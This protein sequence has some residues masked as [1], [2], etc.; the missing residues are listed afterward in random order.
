[1]PLPAVITKQLQS[2]TPHLNVQKYTLSKSAVKSLS[3][4][5]NAHPSLTVL[6]L[7]H[8]GLTSD[9]IESLCR[10]IETHPNLKFLD[11]SGNPGMG[12]QSIAPAIWS[13]RAITLRGCTVHSIGAEALAQELR[14]EGC[15]RELEILDIGDNVIGDQGG[16][17]LIPALL[18]LPK[19]HSLNVEENGLGIE[20]SRALGA[21]LA[22]TSALTTLN[23]SNNGIGV[24]GCIAI[25]QGLQNNRTLKNLLLSKCYMVGRGGSAEAL[26]LSLST[27]TTLESIDLSFNFLEDEAV[28]TLSEGI[29]KNTKLKKIDMSNNWLTAEGA[30]ALAAAKNPACVLDLRANDLSK[31]SINLTDNCVF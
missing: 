7:Q 2:N 20:S 13:L 8:C 14:L 9:G 27:H 29:A 28:R 30:N 19:L 18:V 26:A 15:G 25:A 21:A 6:T 11:L 10:A 17:V 23:M 3:E 31:S 16:A 1:M 5:I 12:A 22:K 4:Q 24:F